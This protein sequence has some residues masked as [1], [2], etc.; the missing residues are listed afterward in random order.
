M[1]A[2]RPIGDSDS[3][4]T[5]RVFFALWPPAD[6]VEKLGQTARQ[7]ADKFGGRASRAD[8]LHLTLVFLG[9]VPEARVVDLCIA[10]R[11]VRSPAFKLS[12]ERLGSWPKKKLLWA[13]PQTPP[14]T[15]FS[16]QKSLLETLHLSG[17]G[18]ADNDRKFAPHVT[19]V[20]DSK[21][22]AKSADLPSSLARQGLPWVCREFV[23]VRSTRLPQGSS[24]RV[25]EHF[26][27]GV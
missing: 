26:S 10:A 25:I 18:G 4:L 19:L 1:S 17:F 23:L 5:A 3:P 14:E 15:L 13:A 16:L 20:R 2:D 8:T 22:D 9:A 21:F 7:L 6:V 24:Y 12:I 11:T 27:L